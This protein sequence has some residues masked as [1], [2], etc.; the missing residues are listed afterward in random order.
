MALPARVEEVTVGLLTAE[1]AAGGAG[2]SR[3]R[4]PARPG[5]PGPAGTSPPWR[6]VSTGAPVPSP[7]LGYWACPPGRGEE[8]PPPAV[9]DGAPGAVPIPSP[10][11]PGAAGPRRAGL[12][13]AAAAPAL[14]GEVTSERLGDEALVSGASAARGADGNYCGLMEP[15]RPE[16]SDQ[17]LQVVFW[18]GDL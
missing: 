9:P 11:Q 16:S 4:T 1:A 15:Q 17:G 10:G 5:E 3:T 8:P 2:P 6:Q 13:P 14:P 7:I 18:A 12:R